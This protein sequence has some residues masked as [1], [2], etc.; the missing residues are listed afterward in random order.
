MLLNYCTE[1]FSKKNM[2]NYLVFSRRDQDVY[3]LVVWDEIENLS[4]QISNFERETRNKKGFL[5]VKPEFLLLNLTRFFEIEK[6]RHALTLANMS[7]LFFRRIWGSS[8]IWS[9]TQSL[10]SSIST[11]TQ[12]V[13]STVTWEKAD[14]SFSA[15]RGAS[16]L[17]HTCLS[18]SKNCGGFLQ[19]DAL[20]KRYQT[21]F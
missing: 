1:D 10:M 18:R 20:F 13:T 3:N 19:P 21:N 16:M 5:M 12:R 11:S 17:K 2:N 14:F 7:S 4:H 15:W 6:S 9:R 8:S